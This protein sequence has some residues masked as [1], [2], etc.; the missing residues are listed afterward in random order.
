MYVHKRRLIK[1]SAARENKIKSKSVLI[2]RKIGPVNSRIEWQISR[3][4]KIIP[5]MFSHLS[6]AIEMDVH[7]AR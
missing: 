4:N 5:D 3:L 7:C 2:T 1:V 6:T